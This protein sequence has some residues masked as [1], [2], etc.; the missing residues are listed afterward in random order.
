MLK[1]LEISGYRGFSSYRMSDLTRVNLVVGKNNCG[2]TSILE[3]AE[4]LVSGGN[5]LVIHRLGRRRQEIGSRYG[6]RIPGGWAM[7]FS[8]VF[9]GH[10]LDV[11]SSFRV[12]SDDGTRSVTVE[13]MAFDEADEE[14]HLQDSGQEEDNGPAF[15]FVLK[16]NSSV[17]N[18]PITLPVLE[19]RSVVFKRQSHAMR[20]RFLGS[21]TQFL[22]VDSFDPARMNE[23]WNTALADSLEGEIINDM[24][25]LVPS[26]NSI[27]FLTGSPF[28]SSILLG[29]ANGAKRVPISS[30]GDGLRRLLALRLSFVGTSN[31]FLLADEIDTGLHWTVMEE[32]WRFVVEI[33]RKNNVQVFATTHSYDCI[34]GL[35]SLIHSRDDLAEEVCIQKVAPTIDRAVCLKGEQ[36]KAA[37]EQDIEVR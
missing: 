3:A 8:H 1:S 17:L 20:D 25:I 2:K 7:D 6:P 32:M 9:H 34:R 23:S 11:G 12:L 30:F 24:K 29:F 21:P 18:E 33:A 13:V 22:T 14:L 26:L 19:D 35:A 37:I 28:G 15:A 31:G 36:V 5:P 4:V 16:I 27:H 10:S